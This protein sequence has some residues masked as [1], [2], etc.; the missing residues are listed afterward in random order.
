MNP[1][2]TFKLP[3]PDART[4]GFTVTGIVEDD[5]RAGYVPL[6]MVIQSKTGVAADRRLVLTIRPREYGISPPTNGL[7]VN[8]P[9]LVPQGTRQL[10]ISQMIPKWAVGDGLVL[11]LF[12][13]GQ[14]LKDYVVDLGQPIN[15]RNLPTY[16][17]DHE[18]TTDVLVVRSPDTTHPQDW[19]VYFASK[20]KVNYKA[21]ESLPTDWRAFQYYD[22]VV[23][24]RDVLRSLKV[25]SAGSN[26]SAA[27]NSASGNSA[28]DG[29]SSDNRFEA[30][31]QWIL[32]GGV[33]VVAGPSNG[34]PVGEVLN[35][36]LTDWANSQDA[37][38]STLVTGLAK[39]GVAYQSNMKDLIKIF[40]AGVGHVVA[41][42][43]DTNQQNAKLQTQVAYAVAGV[44][45]SSTLRRGVEPLLGDMRYRRWLIPGVAQ[46]PVYTFMGLLTCFVVLVGPIAYRKTT[47][48]GRGYLMFAIAPILALLTTAAMF[49][50]GVV[51]DGFGTSAR[52]RQLTW[53]DGKSG[54]AFERVRSTYFAGIRPSQG[55]RFPP[56][57]EVFLYQD[58][59]ET[60]DELAKRSPEV[61]G[62]VLMTHQE[63][64]FS[65]SLLPSRQQQQFVA[66]QPRASVGRL[67]VKVIGGGATAGTISA[68]SAT[69]PNALA[70]VSSTMDIELR[71]LVLRDASGQYWEVAKVPAKANNVPC[72]AIPSRVASKLLGN[73]YNDFRPLADVSE[74]PYS[75]RNRRSQTRELISSLNQ[76]L[77][78]ASQITT[79]GLLEEYLREAMQLR[80]SLPKSSFIAISD[81][82]DDVVAVESTELVSSVRYVFGTFP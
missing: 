26:A 63:Q 33:V 58:G 67:D 7:I 82:T 16:L 71:R 11:Q 28:S 61:F 3:G 30:L 21:A 8:V 65:S 64:R 22:V 18:K 73:L 53:V 60:W 2:S 44:G 27:N 36:H 31:R 78:S 29:A 80:N 69:T 20:L 38:M 48:S 24:G 6:R 1:P 40:S 17:L 25:A 52:I 42:E 23:I 51:A 14:E 4:V 66:S 68:A 15:Q 81:V 9:I 77:N 19:K 55:L 70:S 49:T 62:S 34:V 12:E 41:V 54:D 39:L 59:S 46:P 5:G 43:I 32:S 79:E 57:A 76:Q 50:Y 10:E 56:D 72:Q 45:V 35:L 13:D 74:S 47:K 75:G 37:G